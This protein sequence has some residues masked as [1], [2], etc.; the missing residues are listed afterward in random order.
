MEQ[1]RKVGHAVEYGCV[2]AEV[3]RKYTVDAARNLHDFKFKNHEIPPKF[4]KNSVDL[5]GII[6]GRKYIAW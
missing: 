2:E 5:S 6:D 1:L 3:M 4:D